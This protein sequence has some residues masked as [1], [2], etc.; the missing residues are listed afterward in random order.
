MSKIFPS[1][2][3]PVM[4]RAVTYPKGRFD[5]DEGEVIHDREERLIEIECRQDD[6]SWYIEND[7]ECAIKYQA[8]MV[9]GIYERED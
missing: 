3:C 2:I 6:C 4:S 5:E 1:R 7:G 8:L 9:S